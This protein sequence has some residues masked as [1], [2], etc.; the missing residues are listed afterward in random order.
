MGR[1]KI[2]KEGEY[3]ALRLFLKVSVVK[4]LDEMSTREHC[5]RVTLI[6]LAVEKYIHEYETKHS[7]TVLNEQ[8]R[9]GKIVDSLFKLQVPI[10]AVVYTDKETGVEMVQRP[11][12][13]P[14]PLKPHEPP[15][16]PPDS[17]TMVMEDGAVIVFTAGEE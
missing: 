7:V 11:G 15:I 13:N 4:A 10:G 16:T 2:L 5:D 9:K 1:R 6:R 17:H 8:P 14:Y 3:S 12:M